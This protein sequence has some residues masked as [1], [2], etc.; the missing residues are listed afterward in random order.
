ML[1][2]RPREAEW[3][4][5]LIAGSWAACILVTIPLARVVSTLVADTIGHH[6][7]IWLTVL[8][9]VGAVL[10]GLGALSRRRPPPAAYACLTIFGGNLLWLT[11][12][13]R[14][15]PVEAFHLV[16]YGILSM[17]VYRAL[18]HRYTDG[19]VFVLS[20]LLTTMVGILDEWVQWLI[21]E[22]Y[23][24][25]RDVGINFT[26]ALL[27]QG[28]LATGLRPAIVSGWPAGRTLSRICY[29]LAGVLAMLCLS[30][31][32]TPDRIAWY[33]ERLPGATFLLDGQSMM[34]EYGHLFDDPEIGLFRSRFDAEQLRSLDRKRG[35]EAARIMSGY[36]EDGEWHRFRK[37]YTVPRDPYVHELGTHLFR[38]NRHLT[39]A[40]DK[41][42]PQR[43]RRDS[44]FIAQSEN[45]ILEKYFPRAIGE[46]SHAWGPE[47]RLE[48]N[49]GAEATYR[50]E[51]WV[52][53]DL[54]TGFS[55][56][57]VMAGFLALIGASL[58]LGALSAGRSSDPRQRER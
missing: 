4:S 48:V 47:V 19:G 23:W 42:R 17:L 21:P 25:L 2:K 53:H 40:R 55:R 1:D 12:T 45:R 56:R 46:S 20:V 50:Y 54:I 44:Y 24:G 16:Q 31:A 41:T 7:F 36:S 3:L 22:R 38:R 57:Q 29:S 13:L 6:A 27:A 35:G 51:S 8:C 9:I 11:W 49:S 14:G 58:L 52:S 33:A 30:Y 32:N 39:L 10:W 34:V 18:L 28:A 43:K 15:N 37:S 5:W 26:A